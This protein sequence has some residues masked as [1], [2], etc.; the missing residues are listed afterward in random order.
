MFDAASQT[1]QS[2]PRED[3]WPTFGS[4][5]FPGHGAINGSPVD[6]CHQCWIPCILAKRLRPADLMSPRPSLECPVGRTIDGR[7]S[8]RATIGYSR[9]G[10]R[11]PIGALHFEATPT[12]YSLTQIM[13]MNS[14]DG[15]L[16]APQQ[17]PHR[18][19]YLPICKRQSNRDLASA[20]RSHPTSSRASCLRSAHPSTMN[21]TR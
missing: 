14:S 1:H 19:K 8:R 3:R 12:N 10:H 15:S 13:P 16:G 11:H 2:K 6:C 4:E 21:G 18:S 9:I 5:I 17:N 7:T 20:A